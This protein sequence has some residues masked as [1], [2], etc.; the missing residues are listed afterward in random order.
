[1]VG[2]RRTNCLRD[3]SGR[4]LQAIPDVCICERTI[5]R[6]FYCCARREAWPAGKNKAP[7]GDRRAAPSEHGDG[8]RHPP[9]A[10]HIIHIHTMQSA[11]NARY[12]R[13]GPPLGEF[14]SPCPTC[15]GLVHVPAAVLATRRHPSACNS[16]SRY[17][18]SP[19]RCV[20]APQRAQATARPSVHLVQPA[21][22]SVRCSRLARIRS[23]LCV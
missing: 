15:L 2:R 21:R 9:G 17:N 1:M 16:I 3:V 10:G 19:C 13:P 5:F 18:V 12:V 6:E 4:V 11:L 7:V 22:I 23:F 20:S 14:A 8:G